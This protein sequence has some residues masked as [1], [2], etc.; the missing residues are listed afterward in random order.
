MN[1]QHKPGATVFL[2]PG[3]TTAPAAAYRQPRGV[4]VSAQPPTVTVDLD[5]GTRITTHE[6]NVR[7]SAPALPKPRIPKPRATAIDS[8]HGVET[9]IFDFLS[10]TPDASRTRP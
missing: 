10:G 3:T 6:R 8:R 9:T 7:A 5:D 2:T 4:V 1:V